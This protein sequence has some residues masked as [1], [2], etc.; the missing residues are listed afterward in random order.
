MKIAYR[1]LQSL[2]REQGRACDSSPEEG[3]FS[4]EQRFFLSWAQFWASACRKEQ[5]L[6]LLAVDPHSPAS[7]R[8]YAPLKNLSEFNAAFDITEADA[9]YLAPE[10][11]MTIWG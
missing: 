9:M 3:G 1:A 8:A 5:A 7:L 6:K 2:Y 4:P 10:H 11:R